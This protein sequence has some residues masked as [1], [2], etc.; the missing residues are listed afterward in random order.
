MFLNDKKVKTR[1]LVNPCE[2]EL[3]E[4]PLEAADEEALDQVIEKLLDSVSKSA[5]G[6]S[7][8]KWSDPVSENLQN[9]SNTEWSEVQP[10]EKNESQSCGQADKS[11]EPPPKKQLEFVGIEAEMMEKW[12]SVEFTETA[13]NVRVKPSKEK[14]QEFGVNKKMELADQD[15]KLSEPEEKLIRSN[16]SEPVESLKLAYG[17][18]SGQGIEESKDGNK[19]ATEVARPRKS[20]MKSEKSASIGRRASKRLAGLEA[21]PAVDIELGD[22]SLKRGRPSTQK[23]PRTGLDD[24]REVDTEPPKAKEETFREQIEVETLKFNNE[25]RREQVDVEELDSR[26]RTIDKDLDCTV[27]SPFGDS[28]PDPCIEFAFKTLTGEIPVLDTTTMQGF[29]HEQLSSVQTPFSDVPHSSAVGDC[30]NGPIQPVQTQVSSAGEDHS[31]T[32]NNM[33]PQTS[34]KVKKLCRRRMSGK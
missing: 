25:D 1:N 19:T 7:N 17:K 31:L 3:P 20:R 23:N 2:N 6:T 16:L 12:K 34:G 10:K 26:D 32:E 28:W 8:G 9:K 24:N 11:V 29:L 22:K 5:P 4:N 13:C 21:E 18:I 30:P 15:G 27:A 14:S 33:L